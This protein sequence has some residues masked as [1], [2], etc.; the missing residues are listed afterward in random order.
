MEGLFSAGQPFQQKHSENRKEDN[1]RNPDGK[2]KIEDS[3]TEEGLTDQHTMMQQEALSRRNIWE[4][5]VYYALGTESFHFA[6]HD[7]S[8]R[9]SMDTYG[10][11]IWPG[12]VALSQ[13]LENNQQQIN[14][15][16]KAVLELGAGTGLL[17]IV[18]SLLGAWV[19]ATDLPDVLT[20]L[21]FNLRRNTKGRSRYTPQVAALSWGQ[22]LDR[23]F[24][25]PSYR[26]DYVLAADVVYHHNFLEELLKTMHHFCRTGSGTTLLWANKI[27]FPSD[28]RF[29]E[30]FN[31]SFN[32]TLLTEL[33]QQDVRIYKATAKE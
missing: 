26:Y 2:L 6:G 25:Y 4:P 31:S 18:A 22:D 3:S 33:P 11:L 12:A 13:F 10:A 15:M 9:E 24:P 29:I 20:N 23:L 17:S 5:S 32:T 14:L 28:L 27:R 19:M 16:D 30:H 1:D 7:I 21:T 8:I